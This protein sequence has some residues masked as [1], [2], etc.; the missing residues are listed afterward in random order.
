MSWHKR[1]YQGSPLQRATIQNRF[2]V[3]W[4]AHGSPPEMLMVEEVHG[5]DVSTLWLRLPDRLASAFPELELS[6]DAQLP[7][8]MRLIAG[9][10]QQF[11]AIFQYYDDGQQ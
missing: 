2:D 9:Y 10:P 1:R 11:E 5:P 7:A 8:R 6:S 4:N 3:L